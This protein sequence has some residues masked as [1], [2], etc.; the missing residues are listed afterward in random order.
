M[1]FSTPREICKLNSHDPFAYF[2]DV[3]RKVSTHLA[4]KIDKLLAS[5]WK[6]PLKQVKP[7]DDIAT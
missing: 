3:L 2:N 4:A 6:K 7:E 5:N 1:N